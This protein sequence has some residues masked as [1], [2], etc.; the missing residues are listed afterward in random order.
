[1]NHGKLCDRIAQQTVAPQAGLP[2]TGEHSGQHSDDMELAK[3]TLL[4]GFCMATFGT[5]PK[6]GLTGTAHEEHG[7]RSRFG[8]QM[9]RSMLH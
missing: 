1:M 2:L 6:T 5:E 7:A 3:M 4:H 9:I 8:A